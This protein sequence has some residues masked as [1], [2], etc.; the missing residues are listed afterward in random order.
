V[1]DRG[2]YWIFQCQ[3]WRFHGRCLV[4]EGEDIMSKF[5]IALMLASV[6]A[7]TTFA[8]APADTQTPRTKREAANAWT[9]AGLE[10]VNVKGLDL[11]YAQPGSSL[12]GYSKV[13]LHPISVAFQRNWERQTTPGSRTPIRAKD[14]QRIKDRLSTLVR[15][16]LA[17]ELGQGGYQIVEAAAD[18]VLEVDMS[19][20]DLKITAPDIPAANVRTFAVSA[21][22]MTLVAELRDSAS[23]DLIMR[24]FDRAQARESFSPQRI[25]NVENAAEARAAASGWAKA[26]RK[27]LDLAKSVGGKS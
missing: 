17:K 3:P 4:A 18:D 7:S 21:G 5:S 11:V 2:E 12:A 6:F 9:E 25:T 8:A 19:I 27:E 10:K 20:V 22:E 26:L 1:Q 23:G 24:V 15:E 14:S 16:E 13:L